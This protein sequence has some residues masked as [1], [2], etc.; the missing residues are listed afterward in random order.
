M[1]NHAFDSRS[2]E[3]RLQHFPDASLL[4]VATPIGNLSDLSQRAIQALRQACLIACEDSRVSR[5]LFDTLGIKPKLVSIE[6][7]REAQAIPTILGHLKAGGSCALISDAGTPAISDPGCRVVRAVRAEGFAVV[8]IPGASAFVALASVS[9]FQPGSIWFEGFLPQRERAADSR[10]QA[11]LGLQAHI[12][13]YEAP[14]RMLKTA[15]ILARL[16]PTRQVCIGRELTKRFE[17]SAVMPALALPGWLRAESHRERGEFTL[18]LEACQEPSPVLPLAASAQGRAD[19]GRIEHAKDEAAMVA[20]RSYSIE[21]RVLML[22]LLEAMAPAQAARLAQRLTRDRQID[23][24]QLA[25]E[26]KPCSAS[27]EGGQASKRAIQG[28]ILG[29]H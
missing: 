22:G 1:M 10:L 3:Q 25:M 8:P 11:L 2:D 5:R 14:H 18:L 7:H 17:E 27:D 24:Y 26:L 12:A 15:A 4:V 21:A 29:E 6:Q 13:L 20:P 19:A 28:P 23:W 16:I 9:G